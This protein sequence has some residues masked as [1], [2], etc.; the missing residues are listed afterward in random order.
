MRGARAPAPV[1]GMTETFMTIICAIEGVIHL[2]FN[3]KTEDRI[4]GLNDCRRRR[5]IFNNSARFELE[6][7]ALQFSLVF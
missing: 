3:G 1:V 4:S 2:D 5:F 6:T 7:K